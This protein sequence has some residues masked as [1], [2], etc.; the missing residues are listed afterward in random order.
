MHVEQWLGGLE[1]QVLGK[2]SRYIMSINLTCE[3]ITATALE[4]IW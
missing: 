2:C 3:Y 4:W 1:Y